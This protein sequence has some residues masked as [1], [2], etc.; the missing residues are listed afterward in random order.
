MC[1]QRRWSL[2][3]KE[4]AHHQQ[5]QRV[6]STGSI[7]TCT[8]GPPPPLS[9]AAPAPMS[10]PPSEPTMRSTCTPMSCSWPRQQVWSSPPSTAPHI[11]AALYVCRYC[12]VYSVKCL[13]VCVCDNHLHL[14]VCVCAGEDGGVSGAVWPRPAGHDPKAMQVRPQAKQEEGLQLGGGRGITN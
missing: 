7:L 4:V 13:A 8:H 6:S 14:A 10:P 11:G 9:L 2:L 12:A 5:N 1:R 3:A